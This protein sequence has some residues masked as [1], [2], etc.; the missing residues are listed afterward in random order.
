MMVIIYGSFGRFVYYDEI[1]TVH[2]IY[3]IDAIMRRYD[4]CMNGE[5]WNTM[6][7]AVIFPRQKKPIILKK[8][9]KEYLFRS[10]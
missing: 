3:N 5:T 7:V 10:F 1:N 4:N 6:P 9:R 2:E 8:S